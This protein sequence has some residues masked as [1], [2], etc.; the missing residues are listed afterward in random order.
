MDNFTIVI[1]KNRTKKRIIKKFKTYENAKKFYQKTLDDNKSVLFG[2][3]TENG[4]NCKY[5]IG[6]VTK[7][8]N[9]KPLYVKDDL[10]RQV[11]IDLDSSEFSIIDIN[12]YKKE[13]YIYDIKKSKRIKV[14]SFLRQYLPKV[15]VK[16]V[17]KL[18]HKISVQ[19]ESDINLFSLKS[20]SDCDRFIDTLSNHFM[21]NGRI[22]T[23]F[24]KDTSVVQKKYLYDLLESNGYSKSILYR[25]F[26]T[27]TRE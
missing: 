21:E 16:L 22:D 18:N 3:E 14:S 6:L 20:D 9:D 19:N 12:P 8:K 26:T 27:Y 17:S 4:K 2:V 15:G 24:V 25:R 13:E 5:E 7:D 23:I 1:F 11:R 10:G